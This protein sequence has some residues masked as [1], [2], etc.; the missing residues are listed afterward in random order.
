[1]RVAYI[2]CEDMPG[3]SRLPSLWN[4]SQC[5]T[6]SIRRVRITLGDSGFLVVFVW[7]LSVASQVLVCW[8]M[9]VADL[10]ADLDYCLFTEQ[11]AYSHRSNVTITKVIISA[12]RQWSVLPSTRIAKLS[13]Q[14][15]TNSAILGHTLSSYPKPKQKGFGDLT[16]AT[17]LMTRAPVLPGTT[18]CR[19]ACRR[20]RRWHCLSSWSD[21]PPGCRRQGQAAWWRARGSD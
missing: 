7:R 15:W 14:Q 1:M 18:G 21:R 2:V 19:V 10:I 20:H 12:E 17:E 13:I 4:V 9:S 6:V 5:L 8:Y 11:V 3:E 16:R